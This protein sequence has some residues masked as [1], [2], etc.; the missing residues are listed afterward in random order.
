MSHGFWDHPDWYD[1]HD[2]TSVAGPDREP[3]HY[4]EFVIALPPIDAGDHVVDLGAGTGKLSLLLADAY[5][6]VGRISLVEPNA[7]KLDRARARV[8]DRI[9][10]RVAALCGTLGTGAPP[11]ISDGTLVLVGS[12]LMPVLLGR[13]GTLAEGRAFVH[14]ALAEAHAMLRPGGWLYDL[15]TVAMPWDVGGEDGPVRRLTLPELTAA[16]ERAGFADVECVYRFRD[17]V[18][19]RAR[20]A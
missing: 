4:R 12:V 14:R 1:C 11:P 15:E 10:E 13:G 3:E 16:V 8:T 20:R 17:R 18:V 19:V 7:P 5:P 2:N 6:R 9:G